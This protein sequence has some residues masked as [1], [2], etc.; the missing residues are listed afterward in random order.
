MSAPKII[1]VAE[2]LE[3]WRSGLSL[4]AIAKRYGVTASGVYYAI[5]PG[6]RIPKTHHRKKGAFHVACLPE[7]HRAERKAI[8]Q[9]NF[10]EEHNPRV[11]E[12]VLSPPAER[13]EAARLFAAGK[14]DRAELMRR[15]SAHSSIAFALLIAL[16]AAAHAHDIG[17]DGRPPP[18]NI[19]A[20]CCGVTEAHLLG[21]QYPLPRQDA[22]GDW[23][24]T[25]DGQKGAW[26]AS[27]VMDSQD[28]CF[29]AWW[30]RA[31]DG[32]MIIFRCLAVPHTT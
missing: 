30:G 29:W 12:Q 10:V 11:I 25:I 16:S 32:V 6:G 24:V 1:P 19:K 2:A 23:W 18:P 26:K 5:V 22:N 15:I 27:E 31:A 13:M 9:G 14:I 28:G 21:G 3:L 7:R 4:R 17:C 8:H 20:Q